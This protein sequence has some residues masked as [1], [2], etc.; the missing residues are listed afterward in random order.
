MMRHQKDPTNTNESPCGSGHKAN[1]RKTS[2]YPNIMAR[3]KS[4]ISRG[5]PTVTRV[6][7]DSLFNNSWGNK[8]KIVDP[9]LTL[10]WAFQNVRGII[11]KE[12]DPTLAS[13]IENLM[14]L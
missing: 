14:K 4:G 9:K 6:G 7:G 8:P 13:G 3:D 12:K 10:R 5:A 2:I 1:E 11:P